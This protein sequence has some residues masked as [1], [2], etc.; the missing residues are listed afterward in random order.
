MGY[1][2]RAILSYLEGKNKEGI[3]V[4]QILEKADI[5]VSETLYI[6]AQTYALLNDH[7]G[8]I[9]LLKKAIDGGYFNYPYM[10][11]DP[12]LQSVQNNPEFQLL[13]SLAK[14]KHE[15]FKQK[16]FTASL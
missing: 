10:L 4:L 14:E 15:T 3:Q 5:Y 7:E 13:L 8:C 1:Y 16:Y 12:F 2:A 11:R 9:R 6:I